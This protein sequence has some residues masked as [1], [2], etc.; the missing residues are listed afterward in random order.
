[1]T[2]RFGDFILDCDTRQLFASGE[3]A[4]LSTKA[5]E[6]LIVLLSNRPCVVSKTELQDRL[7]PSTFV[8]ETNLAGLV[9]EVRRALRDSASRP[10]F[11][12]TVYRIG[13]R[14]VGDVTE[15][16]GAPRSSQP[17]VKLCLLVENRQMPL[18][19]GANAVSYTHL[20][21]PT[22]YSV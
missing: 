15:D 2:Y 10:S 21:L 16:A 12:R 6:L 18:M 19:E 8:Q 22:I 11:V 20:T 1:M 7:W 9:A 3:E 14:F 4:H 17:R 13:Y 5:F